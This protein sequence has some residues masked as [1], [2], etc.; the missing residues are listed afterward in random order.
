[1]ALGRTEDLVPDGSFLWVTPAYDDCLNLK[2]LAFTEQIVDLSHHF[3]LLLGAEKVL[4]LG[5]VGALE[6]VLSYFEVELA[7]VF[8]G[9]ELTAKGDECGV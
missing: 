4:F 1:M 9:V 7:V 8:E 3:F 2:V 5:I 6:D